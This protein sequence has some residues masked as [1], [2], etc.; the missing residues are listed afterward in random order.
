MRGLATIILQP[1]TPLPPPCLRLIASVK[2]NLQLKREARGRPVVLV[3]G[4]GWAAH[5]CIKVIDTDKFDVI[6]VSPR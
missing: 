6:V 5:S 1:L 3:L 2:G 4:S